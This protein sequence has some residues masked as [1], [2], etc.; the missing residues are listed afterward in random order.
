M[1]LQKDVDALNSWSNDNYSKFNPIKCKFMMLSRKRGNSAPQ[2]TLFLMGEPIE[3][4]NSFKY[5]GV[6]IS[7][8]LTW[9]KH[10]QTISSKARRIIGMLYRQ[11]YR[12]TSTPA[13]LHSY[14]TQIRPHLEYA[15][16]VWDP[17][18]A[19]DI[20]LLEGVQEKDL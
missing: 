9:S 2:H 14:K 11:F 15:S 12:Y 1:A 5:L 18:L 10:I 3:K 19:K 8:D 4:V 16:V 7:D 20:Q 13:L 17:Y 6:T